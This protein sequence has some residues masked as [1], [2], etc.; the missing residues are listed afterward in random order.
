MVCGEGTRNCPARFP[1]RR[2]L[3]VRYAGQ[4]IDWGPV[5]ADLAV[6]VVTAIASGAGES[7]AARGIE[8]AGRL[9][10]ALRAR[11]RGDAR[12]RGARESALEDPA[13]ASARGELEALLRERI[14]R[15]A[16]FRAWLEALWSEVGPDI[17]LEAGESAN[18]VHGNVHGDVVQARDVHGG[19][20]IG[21]AD[22]AAPAGDGMPGPASG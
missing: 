10:S 3:R 9:A 5:V 12:A 18:I 4:S 1:A 20:H 13:D 11:L 22:G 14:S 21:R 16:E 15:D 8:A 2:L 17:R 19:I 7:L 6:E